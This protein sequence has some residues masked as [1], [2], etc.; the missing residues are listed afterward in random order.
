MLWSVFGAVVTMIINQYRLRVGPY[1]L[2]PS[3]G[4][5]SDVG[6]CLG[7]VGGGW[8]SLCSLSGLGKMGV[9]SPICS[10]VLHT[11]VTMCRAWAPWDGCG[12]LLA[13][14]VL[15]Y[16]WTYLMEPNFLYFLSG[17]RNRARP[18]L[19]AGQPSEVGGHCSSSE[20]SCCPAASDAR[21]VVTLDDARS[22]KPK[23]AWGETG[24]SP[25][26]R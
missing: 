15:R 25:K 9:H 8:G 10:L 21:S 17:H 2:C 18:G 3:P 24:M 5:G 4:R 14:C 19:S 7:H 22:R 16:P 1:S 23:Y 20:A 26:S 12:R 6:L 13:G 11:L